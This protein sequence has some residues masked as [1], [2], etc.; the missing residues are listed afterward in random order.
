MV[1]VWIGILVGAV[2]VIFAMP[3]ALLP[4]ESDLTALHPRP[5]PP[6]AAAADI[7]RRMG[8][9]PGSMSVYLRAASA[10]ELVRL[11]YAVDRRLAT[12]AVRAAGVAG[13]IGL[14]SLLPDPAVTA[15][16]VYP[17]AEVDRVIADFASAVADTSFDPAAFGAYEAF[18]RHTLSGPRVP[19]VSDLV[20]YPRL[21]ESLLSRDEMARHGGD[22][23][24]VTLL[25]VD[26]PLAIRA[27]R[28]R[29]VAAVRA[30]LRELPGATLTGIG[31]A[32][33][34]SD[35][36]VARDLPRLFGVVV[37]LNG[38]F[39]LGHFRS[40]RRAGL[41]LLPA[42][43]SLTLRLAVARV[44]HLEWNMINLVALPLLIGIDVDYGI[45]LVSLARGPDA[46]GRVATS[47]HSV[48]VSAVGN[49]LGFASLLTTAVPA[50]RSLGWAVAVGVA[51][52]LVG[53]LT[54]L[55]PVLINRSERAEV[56]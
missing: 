50:M 32:S 22:G 6:L 28:E 9:D 56:A 16:R 52:C 37:L 53:T 39:L 3:G 25:L 13:T 35:R 14:S 51:L 26:R 10:D 43:V 17:P 44:S 36:T 41:A 42:M 45:Y 20:A 49:V 46:R 33:L 34:S 12:P 38:L 1:R 48:V 55:V 21:A 54:L 40:W 47:G 19:T 23:E 11:A 29:A 18:L 5:N 27:D 7:S 31:V 4:F 8:V 15:G 24:A 30:A 2:V